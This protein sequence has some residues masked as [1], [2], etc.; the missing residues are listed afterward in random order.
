MLMRASPID[1]EE[2]APARTDA[3]ETMSRL[4]F[5]GRTA[6][7]RSIGRRARASVA[8][9]AGA[10][11]TV[12][13]SCREGLTDTPPTLWEAQAARNDPERVALVALYEAT[14]GPDWVRRDGWTTEAPLEEWHGVR[15]DAAGRVVHLDL[16]G[17]ELNGPLPDELSAL[18]RLERL[19]LSDNSLTGPVPAWLG[20][21]G[22]LEV[23]RLD[24]NRLS[25]PLPIGLERLTRLE[26]LRLGGNVLTGPVPPELGS[27][28]S[29]AQLDLASNHLTGALPPELADL[30]ALVRLDLGDNELSGPIPAALGRSPSLQSLTLGHNQLTGP[31][32]A[33]LGDLAALT[34]LSLPRNRLAGPI[35]ATIGR[36]TSLR[37]LDLS[38][39][40]LKGPLPEALGD[41]AALERLDLSWNALTGP[42]PGSLRSLVGLDFLR[43]HENAGLCVPRTVSFAGWTATARDL[44]ASFCAQRDREALMALHDST[45]GASWTERQGWGTDR[46]L[47]DWHGVDVDSLTGRVRGLSLP[48]NN[49]TGGLPREVAALTGLARLDLS[50]NPLTG[51]VPAPWTRLSLDSLD[52]DGTGLCAPASPRFRDWL[53]AIE[54]RRGP[55]RLC[56][57]LTD[58]DILTTL[59]RVANGS[60][61][62]VRTGWATDAPLREWHGV[63]V[64]SAT[65]RVVALSLPANDLR[66]PLP[67]ELGGLERL[68][69]LNLALNWLSGS[70]PPELGAAN[71][72][73]QLNLEG[74]QL[75]G[76]IPPELASLTALETL[77][78]GYNRL[79]GAV[80]PELGDLRRLAELAV[81][82]N[83]LSGPIPAALASL[84][85]LERLD[86]SGNGLVGP[87]PREFG[88]LTRLD[89][90]SLRS[91]ALSGSIPTALAGIGP[92]TSL[93]LSDNDLTGEIPA[94]LARLSRLERLA[95]NDNR[96]EGS[97]PP[98]L[99][100]LPRLKQLSL[101]G[102]RLTGR[103]PSTLGRLSA[104][105]HLR[106][107]D[108]RL[109]G[110]IPP[111]L[112]DLAALVALD[113]GSNRLAGPIPS[114]LGR[115]DRLSVLS[116]DDNALAG[117]VPSEL[118]GMGA[119]R[120]LDLS[121]NRLS[122][123]VPP[124][125][126]RLGELRSLDL[127]DNLLAGAAPAGLGELGAL[128]SLHLD[129]NPDLDGPLPEALTDLASLEEL[130][131]AGT[132][133]CAPATPGFARWLRTVR[134]HRVRRC[135][136]D[137][138]PRAAAYLV[139]AVQSLDHPV[140]LIAGRH[141]LLR[142]FVAAE[143][144]NA[145]PLPAVR[146]TFF[147]DGVARIV[148]EEDERP[149][150]IPTTLRE[151]R[152]LSSVNVAIP[153]DALRPGVELVVEIDPEGT[154]D[155]ALGVPGRL[156]A[157]GRMALD[158]RSLPPLDLTVVPFLWTPDPDSAIVAIAEGMAADPR[159]HDLLAHTRSLL[160]VE[161]LRV[162]AHEP[163]LTDTNH[164]LRLLSQTQ[165]IWV[166]E[167]RRGHYQ[168]TMSGP[169]TPDLMGGVAFVAHRAS[170]A[171]PRTSTIAH[172]L[173]H[174]MGLRHAACGRPGGAD[175]LF[176][177][178]GGRSGAWGYDMALRR[179]VKPERPD[180]MS[181]CDA[182]G[183]SDYH[184]GNALRY[185]VLDEGTDGATRAGRA[186]R[187]V[188][189]LLLWGR[190]DE[191]GAPVLEPA[192]AARLPPSLPRSDGSWR[193]VGTAGDGGELFAFGFEM[194]EALWN[195]G[196]AGGFA[197]ALPISDASV[198]RLA[199]IEL[200]GPRGQ[201]ATVD[202][203]T[204]R[205]M[206]ILR[207]RRTG[208]V[209]GFLDRAP[210][211]IQADGGRAGD[212]MSSLDALTS[213]GLPRR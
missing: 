77:R 167:G 43:L 138:Q 158:V 8:L 162:R 204:H 5:R 212:P 168:G 195:G 76:P 38:V 68:T 49:L 102:N 113:L 166:M 146:A 161:R 131:A 92:L 34:S 186:S 126:G 169:I 122:G 17:N 85:S 19:V 41:L 46:P 71:R 11:L 90:L 180:L 174:N 183:V 40:S 100:D 16:A 114:E 101:A 78:L 66:G 20:A 48:R 179:L 201:R 87:I 184:F 97:I 130:T 206:T 208:R 82:S 98:D 24:R 150:P 177:H 33:A 81:S 148:A 141:A 75:S 178:A 12:S 57:A 62:R 47:G 213:R 45:G 134:V 39:N 89:R 185:R 140:P 190:I 173:G 56:G 207:D 61:W 44:R 198:D 7:S 187:P 115:L 133:L 121:S 127:A 69:K 51:S 10:A 200:I 64:D 147:F 37:R 197:F 99:G 210:D 9:A 170:F 163:V 144:R 53:A 136:E 156:P 111:E 13:T 35:P 70:V 135:R 128:S 94:A 15:V 106:V 79:V 119:L 202:R 211:S 181:Y 117:G 50:G 182:E 105:S 110:E 142:V 29:L 188:P 4:S 125:L 209:R 172:E 160:P 22:T 175:P 194:A 18:S 132:R 60:A 104:L 109:T 129:R 152:L 32:P 21:L 55:D 107:A 23:L 27:L 153:G 83:G 80:P 112:G 26:D 159:G 120:S 1:G 176:P 86:L 91:N 58:R 3:S 193:L 84:A 36:L 145:S 103:L 124:Q 205:P 199:R 73:I 189:A 149:G 192:V 74:N 65:G 118:Q 93:D 96:L 72:L 196:R 139:Q 108:N 203:S 59:H 30:D 143:R 157:S 88:R 31:I 95:L 2:G 67:P 191:T 25:G 52:L 14:D 155:P 42:V 165:A 171:R 151:D 164:G 6:R 28:A 137:A 154:L 54:T 123:S 116:L 63:E